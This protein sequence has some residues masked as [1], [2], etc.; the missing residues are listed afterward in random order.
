M[1]SGKP[2]KLI[3]ELAFP[4]LLAE[5]GQQFYMVVDATVIGR[6]V[7]VRAL[8]A[9]GSTDWC[10]W[11]IM[12]SVMGITQAFSVFVSRYFGMRDED[13]MCRSV[14]AAFILTGAVGVVMTA[15]G[16]TLAKPLLTLMR[17]PED[18]IADAS[19]YLT[20]LCAGTLASA[21]YNMA[22]SVLRA[23]G[24]GRAPL[25]A[26]ATAAAVNVGLDL[27][28][29]C[30]FRMGV[31]GAALASVTAQACA[32]LCCLFSIRRLG[33]LH[34]KKEHWKPEASMCAEMLRFALPLGLQYAVISVGGIVL[35]S[36]VNSRGST[37]MAGFTAVYKFY[38]L[39]ECTAV[40]IGRSFGAYFSQN[41][42]AGE[43]GRIRQGVRLGLAISAFCAFV[44]GAIVIPGGRTFLRMFLDMSGP[45]GPRALEI[46]YRFL[47]VLSCS[48]I[49][50]Y[51]MYV[52]RAALEGMG[53]PFW[54]M[55]SGFAECAARALSGTVLAAWLGTPAL[56]F[57]E[58]LAW[59]S[60][61]AFTALPY[62]KMQKSMPGR[63][64]KGK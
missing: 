2:L 24:N 42:G 8:A 23:L 64:P 27:L 6:G 4:L 31:F 13:R 39:M 56:F 48:L 45:E 10:Y 22:A 62:I 49:I 43:Y 30:V 34:I 33:V 21:A 52:F 5:M 1:T 19:A 51:P 57:A 36:G 50:V 9:V 7:G 55:T 47:L 38:G 35:Q 17:T 54:P 53:R 20:T 61:L 16:V 26:M 63:P 11:V 32:F 3:A 12:W 40:A 46:G 29:I 41:H 37:F 25:A 59:A 14:A 15:A 60:A 28:F 58:P 44:I 18:V